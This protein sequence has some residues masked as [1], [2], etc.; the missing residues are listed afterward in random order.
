MILLAVYLENPLKSNKL[1][2]LY[3]EKQFIPNL[4]TGA[5]VGTIGV[6]VLTSVSISLTINAVN[7]SNMFP[8]QA[9]DTADNSPIPF[10]IQND[11]TVYVDIS[12]E[13]TNLFNGTNAQNPSQYYQFLT[14]SNNDGPGSPSVWTN[15]TPVNSSILAVDALDFTDGNKD[16]AEI[17]IKL[18]IPPDESAGG[19]SSLITFTA[20]QN[21]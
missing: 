17:E 18:T 14:D 15:I 21:T 10:K 11:G 13:A 20:S 3:I 12:L 9:D 4:I 1:E 7:F 19:K 5:P 16:D 2:N 8:N 6:T